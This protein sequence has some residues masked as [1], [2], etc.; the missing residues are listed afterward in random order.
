M[1][2]SLILVL[3]SEE[4]YRTSPHSSLRVM[5]KRMIFYLNLT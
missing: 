1:A 5:N 3:L 2:K 4:A